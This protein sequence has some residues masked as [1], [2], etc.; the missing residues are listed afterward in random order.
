MKIYPMFN[1][2][3]RHEDIW[4]YEGIAPRIL[5]LGCNHGS[6]ILVICHFIFPTT[7]VSLPL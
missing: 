3:R 5:N 6:F 2:A 4:E 7:T 1:P